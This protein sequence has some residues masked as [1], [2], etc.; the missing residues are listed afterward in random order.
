MKMCAAAIALT[1][2]LPAA[3]F[4]DRATRSDAPEPLL[5][6]TTVARGGHF[7]DRPLRMNAQSVSF[8]VYRDARVIQE[9]RADLATGYASGKLAL[10]AFQELQQAVAGISEIELEDRYHTS[11]QM[12]PVI[13]T[14][15]W[16]QAGKRSSVK[17]FGDLDPESEGRALVPTRLVGIYDRIAGLVL[18]GSASW[19]PKHVEVL[20]TPREGEPEPSVPWPSEWREFKAAD[21]PLMCPRPYCRVSNK[22]PEA[23]RFR[24]FV[25][26]PGSEFEK[27]RGL[28]LGRN[29]MMPYVRLDGRSWTFS[30]YLP[31]PAEE[32]WT[33]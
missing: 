24:A 17:V 21:R 19:T 33:Q 31:F 6:L 16:W 1:L 12:H 26:L 14:F 2:L 29:D 18:E 8:V 13:R 3:T 32:K 15:T 5:V 20:L 27:L 10:E 25:L 11:R 30:Y 23:T 4:A 28:D 22:A 7:R 9:D